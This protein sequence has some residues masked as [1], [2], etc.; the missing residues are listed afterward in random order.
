MNALN[1]FGSYYQASLG[2]YRDVKKP[3]VAK[4][5]SLDG[6]YFYKFLSWF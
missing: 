5:C 4:E 2:P 1:A 6:L 3:I